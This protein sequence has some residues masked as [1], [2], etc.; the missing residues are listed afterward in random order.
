MNTAQAKKLASITSNTATSV[1]AKL[2]QQA[3][4]NAGLETPM[5][6]G[7][8]L[9][10][11]EKYQKI[12]AAFTDISEALGLDLSDDSLQET[13]HRIAKMYVQEIFS[14]LDYSNFPKITVIENKMANDEMIMVKDVNLTSTCEH[15]FVTIDGLAKVAY[16][17]NKTLIGLSKINRLV[18]FFAQRPQVQERLTKQ[19][20]I[21]LKALL[22]TEHVA[23]SINAVHY[24]VKARGVMDSNSSTTTTALSGCFKTNSASRAE[25]ISN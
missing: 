5:H 6:S 21:A 8:Q 22:G 23:V 3:L 14:G 25:F 9:S 7:T 12:K 2:V 16:I 1:E 13:P 11:D 18:R 17:P 4:I 19:I 10:N 15:H 20:L 24:C